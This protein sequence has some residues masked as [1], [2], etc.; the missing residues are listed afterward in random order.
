MAQIDVQKKK[1]NPLPWVIIILLVLAVAG[2]L[3]WRN[4]QQPAPANTT[5]TDTTTTRTDTMQR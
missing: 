5:T 2:Y 4:M 1:A 3:V